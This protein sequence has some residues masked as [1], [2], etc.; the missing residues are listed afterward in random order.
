MT[1]T[2]A[3]QHIKDTY[4]PEYV[5]MITKKAPAGGYICPLCGSGAGKNGHHTGA[6]SVHGNNWKC[7]SCDKGGDIFDLIGEYE[8]I[9]G[10]NE[11]LNRASQLFNVTID[12]YTPQSTQAPQRPP[13][14]PPPRSTEAKPQEQ[15]TA[16]YTAYYQKCAENLKA[17]PQA[18]AYLLSRGITLDTASRYLIGF[19]GQ[20]D[21]T[22]APGGIGEIRHPA[23]R[24][25]V[26]FD[27]LHYL[28]RS[29][30]P[31]TPKDY[32]KMNNTA[33]EG[34]GKVPPFNGKIIDNS[35][36]PL[37]VTEGAFDA[38]SI[39]EAGGEA[40]ATNSTSNVDILVDIMRQKNPQRPIIIAFD[41]DNPGNKAA[42]SLQAE[43]DGLHITAV[44]PAF[45]T[46][47]KDINE[48]LQKDRAALN[49]YISDAIRAAKLPAEERKTEYYENRSAK[50]Y[51]QKF[52]D[53]IRDS[54]KKDCYSTGL[55]S[56]D[57]A[58]DGGLYAGLYFIGAI[59]SLG[60]TTF[61][62]QIADNIAK[63]GHDVLY[64]SLE[65]ARAELMAK[66]ISRETYI[67]NRAQGG[68]PMNA[69]STRGILAGKRYEHYSPEEKGL[70]MAACK[71]YEEYS[72]HIFISEG[73]GDIGAE[74]IKAAIT[75]HINFTGEK[76][77]VIIDYLQILAPTDTHNSDK[78]NTDKNVLE[79]KRISRD[80]EIP[81]IGI[82][83]FNRDNYTAPVNL[84]SFKE[85]GAVEYSADA[86]IG[87]QFLGMDFEEGEAD[88]AREKRIRTLRAHYEE[89][90]RIGEDQQIQVK[91]LKQRNAPKCDVILDF[92]PMFN[93]FE[94]CKEAQ[95]SN[96]DPP[97][98]N[99]ERENLYTAFANAGD[100]T[101]A[102]IKDIAK[103]LKRTAGTIKKMLA[104]YPEFIIDIDGETVTL[105]ETTPF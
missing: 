21:P 80:L 31:N 68:D 9:A 1:R 55:E 104:K 73:I 26:P 23:P 37:F 3:T 66:S 103:A 24:I 33:A 32:Q 51:I 53:D 92:Y 96:F 70:I 75:E 98:D 5:Q 97:T 100:G 44:K 49:A 46:A 93:Y 69:K 48:M 81:I 90:G 56:L 102:K 17:S 54:K 52:L 27:T 62:M 94:E 42:Q 72:K 16:D 38:L 34:A 28:G 77:I 25:I 2:E 58:L 86:L 95:N 8:Q 10:F 4:L 83:S 64:F 41:N 78:Q 19:D 7:F 89:K 6:F 11:R 35:T 82:S 29:I 30:D 61:V 50:G 105:E 59:S 67:I 74:Q 20:A 57:K 71:A 91:V 39:I 40:I 14:A 13:Q 18:Q 99:E 22:A 85:S 12:S 87:L 84:A 88:K 47:Y 65:M 36:E 60:K 101:T 63:A 79:L 76:P 45:P 15:P 43:L